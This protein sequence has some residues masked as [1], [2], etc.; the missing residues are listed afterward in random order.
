MNESN[1]NELCNNVDYRRLSDAA[2]K[3]L[4]GDKL[5]L[6]CILKGCVPEFMNCHVNDIENKYIEGEPE[7]GTVGVYPETTNPPKE[8]S[9][10]RVHGIN[11]E[12]ATDTEGK[13]TFDI[14]FYAFT[15]T[16]ERIKL[17]INVESQNEFYH[18]YPLIKRA[19]F[20]ACR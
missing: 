5:I 11:A 6:A 2:C 3:Q 19:I 4:L 15:P 13:V 14:R 10:G 12:D 9:A 17:I 18:S 20:Y 16:K 1:V 8:K 7:I